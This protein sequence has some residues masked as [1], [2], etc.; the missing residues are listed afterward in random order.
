MLAKNG[1]QLRSLLKTNS[2]K[3]L[4]ASLTTKN[5]KNQLAQEA[6]ATSPKDEP[7]PLYLDAQSTTPM[8]PRVLDAMLPYMTS[9]YGNP[10]S[11]YFFSK[12]DDNKLRKI[13]QNAT[14]LYCLTVDNFDFTRKIEQNQFSIFEEKIRQNETVLYCLAIDNF[15]L[16]RKIEENLIFIFFV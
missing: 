15:D 7:R 13:R 9:Y 8:D 5:S 1:F 6:E 16:T 12:M 10:H 3:V 14:V 11:R 2:L 4:S